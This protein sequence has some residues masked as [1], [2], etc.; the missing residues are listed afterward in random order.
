MKKVIILLLLVTLFSCNLLQNDNYALYTRNGDGW[1]QTFFEGKTI[2]NNTNFE[3]KLIIVEN[4]GEK[5]ISIPS[6]TIYDLELDSFI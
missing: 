5:V 6:G 1:E 4:S 3:M 2:T